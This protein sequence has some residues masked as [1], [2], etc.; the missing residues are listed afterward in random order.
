MSEQDKNLEAAAK[1]KAKEVADK[2]AAEEKAKTEAVAKT[3]EEIAGEKAK[4]EKQKQIAAIKKKKKKGEKTIE[5]TGP[6]AGRFL[7]SHTIGE[8]VNIEGKQAEE[9][10]EYGSGKEV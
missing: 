5:V 3:P 1:A 2:K 7:L 6:L 10:I 9:I 8:I 4:A